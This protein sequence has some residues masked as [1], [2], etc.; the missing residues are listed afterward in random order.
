MTALAKQQNTNALSRPHASS[1]FTPEQAATL[2]NVICPG[3]SDS[4]LD[5]VA[6]VA[7]QTGLSPFLKQLYVQKRWDNLSNSMRLIITTGIDGYRL[8]AERTGKYIGQR[9][10]EWCGTDGQW[11]DIWLSKAPPA[12]ARVT[13]LKAGCEPF[14]AVARFDAYA[15]TVKGGGLNSMWQKMGAEQLA[16][17]AEALALRKAFPQELSGVYTQ[18]EMAQA[19]NPEP[20]RADVIEPPPRAA[21]LPV[22]ASQREDS[23]SGKHAAPKLPTRTAKNYAVKECADKPFT[24]LSDGELSAYLAYYTEKLPSLTQPNHVQAVEATIAAAEMELER[25]IQ[26]EGQPLDDDNAA[27][28]FEEP[29]PAAE[30]ANDGAPAQMVEYIDPDGVVRQVPADSLEGQLALSLAAKGIDRTDESEPWGLS[31]G[32]PTKAKAEKR[33]TRKGAA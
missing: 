7:K 25:R 30:P 20:V 1:Y 5:L 13:V 4:E 6:E 18:E 22:Q 16:K 24:E 2:K 28:P 9:P 14:V 10:Y 17:C 33:A 8:S 27:D 23:S 29:A 32:M 3:L 21:Q 15:Q 31:D 12:A 11:R 26:E 19:E